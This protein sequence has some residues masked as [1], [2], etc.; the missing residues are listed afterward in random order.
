MNGNNHV[1]HLHQS[2]RLQV[3]SQQ[4]RN[5]NGK[6]RYYFA[7]EHKGE[8]IDKVPQGYE[9][10]ESINRIVS[11]VKSHPKLTRMKKPSAWKM[12]SRAIPKRGII[13]L[14]SR[15]IKLLSMKAL[16]DEWIVFGLKKHSPLESVFFRVRPLGAI[17]NALRNAHEL[18]LVYSVGGNRRLWQRL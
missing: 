7:K 3:F 4:R 15:T 13:V 14:Q 16:A 11:L 8:P 1:H 2:Q 9:I 12:R 18:R 5:Q 10:E 17:L 6:P